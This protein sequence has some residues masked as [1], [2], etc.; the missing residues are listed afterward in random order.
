[1]VESTEGGRERESKGGYMTSYLC[2]WARARITCSEREVSEYKRKSEWWGGR[3]M[4]R[5]RAGGC[6]RARASG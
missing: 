4:V 6:V 5:S 2:M 3:V 1:M